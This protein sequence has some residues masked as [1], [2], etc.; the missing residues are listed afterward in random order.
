MTTGV[1]TVDRRYIDMGNL[2]WVRNGGEESH[3]YYTSLNIDVA[4]IADRSGGSIICSAYKSGDAYYR[5]TNKSTCIYTS[6]LIWIYDTD[7]IGLG[8]EIKNIVTGY[9]CVYKLATPITYQLTPTEVR[10]LLG[11]N[12]IWSDTGDSAVTY[13]ADTKKYI[14]TRI[15]ALQALILNS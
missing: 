15:A 5:T 11:Q 4:G 3:Q 2:T 1:L 7:L 14:D 9:K 13:R 12:N 10:T 8:T 6:R